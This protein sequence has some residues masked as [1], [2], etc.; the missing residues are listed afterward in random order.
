MSSEWFRWRTLPRRGDTAEDIT[1]SITGDIT[2]IVVGT[3]DTT[4]TTV[5]MGIPATTV[6]TASVSAGPLLIPTGGFPAR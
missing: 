6:I 3:V 4:D 5:T 1:G 2:A